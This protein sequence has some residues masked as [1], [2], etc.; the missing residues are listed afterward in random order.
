[1]G[2]KEENNF[3]R[4]RIFGIMKSKRIRQKDLANNL[5]IEA[6]TVSSWKRGKSDS[7]TSYLAKI[8][9]AIGTTSEYLTTGNELYRYP[10]SYEA[11]Q[12]YQSSPDV[13][14]EQQQLQ[15]D[16]KEKQALKVLGI[17]SR[18]LAVARAFDQADEGVQ[19]LICNGLKVPV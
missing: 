2:T 1:M 18:A 14:K 6:D 8:A 9:A 13:Q 15:Q 19:Q 17:T 7:F 11:F 16:F 12:E 5:G 3:I 4:D 10:G